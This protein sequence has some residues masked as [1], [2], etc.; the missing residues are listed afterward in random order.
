MPDDATWARR[1]LISHRQLLVKQ[2]RSLKNTI[3]AIFNRL[4]LPDVPSEGQLSARAVVDGAR[5]PREWA[6]L[7]RSQSAPCIRA[8][9]RQTCRGRAARC[10]VG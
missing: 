8:R 10:E 9:G 5:G 7:P 1:Q 3:H 2:Q 6:G 4:L